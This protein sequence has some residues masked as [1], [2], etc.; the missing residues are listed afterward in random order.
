M[1]RGCWV[2]GV[3]GGWRVERVHIWIY[4]PGKPDTSVRT[5]RRGKFYIRGRIIPRH[6]AL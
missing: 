3:G 1:Y 4:P 5:C 6:F 2:E